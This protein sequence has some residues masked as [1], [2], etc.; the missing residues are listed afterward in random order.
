MRE[1]SLSFCQVCQFLRHNDKTVHT[2]QQV[3]TMC[4]WDLETYLHT[5]NSPGLF[6]S[7]CPLPIQLVQMLL[8]KQSASDGL[9]RNHVSFK[10]HRPRMSNFKESTPHEFAFH[11]PR[12][13]KKESCFIY[14]AQLVNYF[15]SPLN[16][17]FQLISDFTKRYDWMLVIKVH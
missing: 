10:V 5:E 2:T 12:C 13:Q 11:K 6:L 7:F 3:V 1:A 16:Q 9:L 4:F 14:F 8:I 15:F 17:S